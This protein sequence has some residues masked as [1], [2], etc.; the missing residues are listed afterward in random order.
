MPPASIEG[1]EVISPVEVE[2]LCMLVVRVGLD[3]IVHDIPWHVFGIQ[4]LSPGLK[5]GCPEV[6]HD[7]LGLGS[8]LD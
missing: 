5:C 2:R 3:V 7:G 1:F 8:Q 4:A 6:H